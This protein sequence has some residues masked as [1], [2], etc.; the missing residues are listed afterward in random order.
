MVLTTITNII[1]LSG[2][3]RNLHHIP[4]HSEHWNMDIQIILK[5]KHPLEK[6]LDISAEKGIEPWTL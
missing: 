5:P 4:K 2:G 1:K 6:I 3:E